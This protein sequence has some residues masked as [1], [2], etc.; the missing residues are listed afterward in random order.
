MKIKNLYSQVTS[1]YRFKP[2][3]KVTNPYQV[4]YSLFMLHSCHDK[5][6][7]LLW[8]TTIDF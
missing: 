6:Q 3:L 5:C 8:L 1:K 4:S 2:L 7:V